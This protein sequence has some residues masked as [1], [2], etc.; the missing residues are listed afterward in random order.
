[1][2][3]GDWA[4]HPTRMEVSGIHHNVFG[5]FLSLRPA[6]FAE[7]R[8]AAFFRDLTYRAGDEVA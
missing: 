8:G 4:R 3:D 2:D 1:M 7:G 6:L 5:G